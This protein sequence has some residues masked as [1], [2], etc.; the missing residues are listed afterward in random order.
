[1]HDEC[2]FLDKRFWAAVLD[3]DQTPEQIAG[4]T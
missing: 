4:V 3:A 2:M 1:M